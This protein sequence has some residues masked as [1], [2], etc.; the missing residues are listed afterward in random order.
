MNG[1]SG[2]G[3]KRESQKIRLRT[4]N[5]TELPTAERVC[6]YINVIL[7]KAASHTLSHTSL[8]CVVPPLCVL[9]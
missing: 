9:V 5:K 8:F 6:V 4:S 1:L 7:D 3:M 2:A